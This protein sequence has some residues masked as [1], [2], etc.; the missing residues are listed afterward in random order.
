MDAKVYHLQF[1]ENHQTCN[2]PGSED[3]QTTGEEERLI[4]V[5]LL[6]PVDVAITAAALA[7]HLR[8]LLK[9]IQPTR[10]S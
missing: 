1:N 2:Q 8:T 3:T 6:P 9:E 7:P 4:A 5:E 10:N